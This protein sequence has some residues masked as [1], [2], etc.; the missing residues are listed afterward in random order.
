MRTKQQKLTSVNFV[1]PLIK[2]WDYDPQVVRRTVAA[3]IDKSERAD[4][5]A[6]AARATPA[7]G[8]STSGGSASGGS[9]EPRTQAVM[10][11]P[12]SDPDADTT[13]LAGVC[14]AG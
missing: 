14:S 7:G 3:A 1:P 10:E 13:D 12:G 4:E 9:S 8:T 6:A 2:P 11:R 5:K